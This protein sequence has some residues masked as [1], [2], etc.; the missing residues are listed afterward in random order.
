MKATYTRFSYKSKAK[1]GQVVNY[2]QSWMTLEKP[3]NILASVDPHE[4]VMENLQRSLIHFGTTTNLDR[5][6][7]ITIYLQ[8][9]ET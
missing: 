5:G 7:V 3:D 2:E 9:G 1:F 8:W 6:E 4:P